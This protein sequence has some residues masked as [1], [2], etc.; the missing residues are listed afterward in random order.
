MLPFALSIFV[1]AFL[2][3][4]V[5]PLIGKYILPW[6]G[7]TPGVW[8]TCLLFFQVAL[9][10]GYAYA[11]WST[12]RLKP[13]SQAIL[14]GILMVASLALLPIIPSDSWKE[15][16][17]GDPTLR[18]LL[19]LSATIGLPYVVLSATGPLMQQWFSQV[20]PGVS[21]YRLYALSNVGSLL[22]L[23]S[24]PAFFEVQFTRVQL[25]VIWSLGLGL[26]VFLAG[27][28]AWVIW[29]NAPSGTTP[30][31]STP[32]DPTETAVSW[33]DRLLWFA[34]PAVA[35]ALLLA[36]TNKLTQEV[37]VIPFL[38]VAP[39][40]LYLCSFIVAFDHSR[41]YERGPYSAFLILA[42]GTVVYLLEARSAAR[43]TLQIIGYCGTLF[44]GC[45]VCH[46]ELYRLRPPTRLLTS[47]Y[48]SIS[49]GGALG[50]LLVAVV[51]PL[52][53]SDYRDLQLGWWVL[54]FALGALAFRHR[55]LDVTAGTAIGAIGVTL[56]VPWLRSQERGSLGFWQEITR[57]YEDYG[58]WVGIGFAVFLACSVEYHFRRWVRY[59]LVPIGGLLFIS[60]VIAAV[61]SVTEGSPGFAVE[62]E[63][64]YTEYRWWIVAGAFAFVGATVNFD[65][66]RFLLEWRPR[67]G[68]FVVIVGALVGAIMLIEMRDRFS[69]GFAHRSRNF[70][71]TLKVYD[72]YPDDPD[73]YY[74]L[75]HGATTHGMQFLDEER[76]LMPT[77]Y[78]GRTSGVSLALTESPKQENRHIGVVGLGTGTMAAHGR[79]GDRVRFYDINTAVEDLAWNLF[80]YLPR[81]PAE[82]EVVIGDAR[83]S[84]EHELAT[85]GGQE[86][87]L[88]VLDAFSS[89]AIP[90]HL[91]TREAFDTYLAHMAP[92]GVIAVHISNRY[93][94]LQ[95]VV[96]AIADEIG[97]EAITISDNTPDPGWWLYRSTWVLVT[98]NPAVI[99]SPAIVDVRESR[100]ERN[101]VLWTDD[102]ASLY[103]ILR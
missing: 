7:G 82:V 36:T 24:F 50:G 103:S 40:A 74:L 29:R 90:V 72:Y 94:D 83:I 3:F 4:Q 97:Y 80:S 6:F 96:E 71:G 98:R 2:L 49:A 19:L 81:T 21:P 55:S 64:I 26:F 10:A 89:D 65:R 52:V 35:T 101:P 42:V 22:A 33:Q 51:A 44:L 31:S 84:L 34:L 43:F 14:H 27:I 68:A 53:F 45:M 30:A 17:S 66:T 93:L 86:F 1:G 8:T 32:V 69:A 70:Y 11:H 76:A 85:G 91:L 18:V 79:A 38:W 60:I 5:Q 39:L 23:L 12:S 20:R 63:A 46:G 92:D 37:A 56:L 102:Y 62:L 78:Y 58:W 88:L 48:L 99:S 16:V 77:S 87:D 75:V 41:W 59:T 57:F 25:A 73:R 67:V 54:I 95:P 28:C 15:Q 13:R 9:L 61:R 47:Y 100:S